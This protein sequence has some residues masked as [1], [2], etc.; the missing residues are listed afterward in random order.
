LERVFNVLLHNHES[1]DAALAA[2][3]KRAV[4]KGLTPIAWTWGKAYTQKVKRPCPMLGPDI[5][6]EIA[7]VP[8]TLT[9]ET[10]HYA[11]W[12]FLASLEHLGA[13]NIIRAVDGAE[14]PPLYRTRGPAC[15]HCR[16]DR[17]RNDT[18][19]LRHEDGRTVQVGSTCIGDFLGTDT[20]DH[21]AASATMFAACYSIGE[22]GEEGAFG[23]GGYCAVT[24]AEYLPLVAWQVRECGWIS[25]TVAREKDDGTAAS[26]DWAW[27]YLTD[28]K[29]QKEAGAYPTADDVALAATAEAWAESLADGAVNAEKGDYLHNLRAIARSGIVSQRSAGI[30]ASAV[31]AYQRYIGRER[32]RAER[33]SRPVMDV[34]VGT[35]GK[36]ETWTV[37][38]E[39]VTGYE[40]A[41]GYTTVCKFRTV[42]GALIIWKASSTTIERS[43]VGKRYQLTG[44]VKAHDDYKGAKQT[45]VLRCK[46]TETE[47]VA[48]AAE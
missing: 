17:R 37:T 39:F 10:P 15:D 32:A 6:I 30:A 25:R 9:G 19:V 48:Q 28:R 35:V 34:H 2:L 11:G 44:S 43:D 29:A 41:Y 14:V 33:A 16:A 40:T 22:E 1:V 46:L 45:L 12:T 36:R 21:L 4:R 27:R 38:L 18:Y 13:E 24:L 5:T 8:L 20:A 3:A 47:A 42:A 31:T 7:R 26:A 23:G